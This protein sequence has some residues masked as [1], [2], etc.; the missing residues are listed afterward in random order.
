MADRRRRGGRRRS[1]A[2]DEKLNVGDRVG[3]AAIGPAEQFD[4][5][6]IAKYG[7]VSSLGSAT[8]A[9]F[10]IPTAQR[11]LEKEGQLDAV[12]AAAEEGVTPEQL[13]E[14]IQA[15]LGSEVTVRTGG[16]QA[17]ED[18]SEI[19]TFTKIIRY[20]LLAFAGIAL[21]VGGFV[22]FNTL[23][24]T[25]ARRRASSPRCAPSARRGARSSPP[26]SSRRS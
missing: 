10:D 9:I 18:S 1:T 5:V 8:F 11:L 15:D 13:T 19:A 21:F 22:I 26:S 12:Q 3:V 2:D 23:S 7:D 24:I 25:V 4:I 14:R 20:F 17:D 16:E 6:G